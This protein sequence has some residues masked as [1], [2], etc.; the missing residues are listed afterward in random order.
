MRRVRLFAVPLLLLAACGHPLK[1]YWKAEAVP[2]PLK[3]VG[4]DFDDATDRVLAHIDRF[5]PNSDTSEHK[6]EPGHYTF[7]AATKAVTV[8]CK[9]MGDGKAE[10]WTGTLAGETLE[11]T[12]GADMVKLVKGG[13]AH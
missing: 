8:K 2:A 9:L 11:L 1:G 7:D 3:K 5:L 10:T 13:A 12:G 4:I 6:H